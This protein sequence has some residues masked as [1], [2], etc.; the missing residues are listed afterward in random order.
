MNLIRRF[1]NIKVSF[2]LFTWLNYMKTGIQF[3][4]KFQNVPK[5]FCSVFHGKD[6]VNGQNLVKF[7]R[8]C[9]N[10]Y[11]NIYKIMHAW[12]NTSGI[13]VSADVARQLLVCQTF[14]EFFVAQFWPPA[15]DCSHLRP[16]LLDP[17]R[18]TS[19]M[20]LTMTVPSCKMSLPALCFTVPVSCDLK[21]L[22]TLIFR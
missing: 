20:S 22:L 18:N 10:Y 1:E 7:Q 2:I 6:F 4:G 3:G 17:L 11:E 8:Y 19:G 14:R 9:L 12:T 16:A 13:L 5:I 15:S 21:H